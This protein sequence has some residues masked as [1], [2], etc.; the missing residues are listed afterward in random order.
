MDEITSER[1]PTPVMPLEYSTTPDIAPPWLLRALGSFLVVYG[2][3][4]I[5]SYGL[6][7]IFL[8]MQKTVLSW[9]SGFFYFVPVEFAL[10]VLAITVG[11]KARKCDLLGQRWLRIWALGEVLF[12]ICGTGFTIFTQ[13]IS[14]SPFPSKPLENVIFRLNSLLGIWIWNLAL[15]IMILIILPRR[16]GKGRYG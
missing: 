14:L 10:A 12:Q 6:N 3:A 8:S 7:F 2:A 5:C 11:L 9:S 1:K 13:P 16:S 15:P 4:E